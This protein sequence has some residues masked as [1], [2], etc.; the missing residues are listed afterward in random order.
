MLAELINPY[1]LQVASFILIN[2]ILGVSIYITLST[3]QLS[4]A[5]AGFMGIGAYTSALLTLN[6]DLPII[7]GILAGT[8]LAGLFGILIGIPTLRL[9]GV[10]LAIV[11]LGFGEVIRVIFVNWESMTKGAVGLSGIPHMGRELLNTLKDLGFDPKI[12]GLQNNQFVFLAIFLILL[13]VTISIIAFFRRQNRSRVGRAFAAIK[14]DEKAAESMGINITYYKVLAFAQGALVAGFAGALFAHVLAYISP[15]DFA[16]HR[17]VEILIFAV[18]GGSEV[19][20]GPVFGA[21]F[22]TVMPEVLRFISEYRYM[23]YG[24]IIII[25]MAVRPQGLIDVNILNWVKLKTSKRR[26]KHGAASQKSM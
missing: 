24:L 9:Q 11:T 26:Q 6:F 15:A 14:L 12:L 2:I 16:Y 1:Y 21:L 10:Y 13:A 17:A 8:L 4:L 5:N 19:I 25:M 7:V 3:G 20:W 22:L 23:I 18:F